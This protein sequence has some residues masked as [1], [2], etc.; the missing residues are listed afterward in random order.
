MKKE[1]TR[2]LVL[3]KKTISNLDNRE[4]KSIRGATLARP[5]CAC[6]VTESCSLYFCC[7]PTTYL[8]ME[9]N[10]SIDC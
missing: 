2:K 5:S 8:N 10:A 7:P 1:L 3:N 9:E 4:M 6:D